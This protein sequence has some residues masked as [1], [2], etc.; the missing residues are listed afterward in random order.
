MSVDYQYKDAKKRITDETHN[1]YFY[2]FDVTN[3]NLLKAIIKMW[4]SLNILTPD[5]ETKVIKES[6]VYS[7]SWRRATTKKINMEINRK[8]RNLKGTLVKINTLNVTAD[9]YD[10][11]ME[12]IE[13]GEKHWSDCIYCGEEAKNNHP[14][15][16][17]QFVC[18]GCKEEEEVEEDE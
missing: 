9:L 6:S 14:T 3:T 5:N 16:F 7:A 17:G 1:Q 11:V 4:N 12:Y 2:K 8:V 15:R 18:D 13:L 10:K